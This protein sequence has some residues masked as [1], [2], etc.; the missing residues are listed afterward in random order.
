MLDRRGIPVLPQGGTMAPYLIWAAVRQATSPTARAQAII[1]H[2]RMSMSKPV[3]TKADRL[4]HL[5]A[6]LDTLADQVEQPSRTIGRAE[7]LIGEGE[8]I[9][10]GVYAVFRG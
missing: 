1:D 2:V 10:R 5:A 9:A 6:E 4:R 3:P 8:R 7:L